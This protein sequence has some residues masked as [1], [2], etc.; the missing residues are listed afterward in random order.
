[1]FIVIYIF[2]LYSSRHF[3]TR[4]NLKKKQIIESTDHNNFLSKE[5]KEIKKCPILCDSRKRN[6]KFRSRLRPCLDSRFRSLIR[7]FPVTEI[8]L[9]AVQYSNYEN[10]CISFER[11]H[12]N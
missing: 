6:C 10:L 3:K 11:K 4:S 1:M 9:P 12:N 8:G 7:N 2:K 5:K